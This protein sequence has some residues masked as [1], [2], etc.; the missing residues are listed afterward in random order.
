VAQL[1]AHGARSAR[2]VPG[3]T[4]TVR[5]TGEPGWG[6]VLVADNGGGEPVAALADVIREVLAPWGAQL[7]AASEPGLGCTFELRLMTSPA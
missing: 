1:V 4:L 5:V 7:E 2:A 3:S 6:S